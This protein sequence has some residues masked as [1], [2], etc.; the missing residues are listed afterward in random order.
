MSDYRPLQGDLAVQRLPETARLCWGKMEIKILSLFGW[1]G[2]IL[3]FGAG[4]SAPGPAGGRGG[5][6]FEIPAPVGPLP[7][8]RFLCGWGG[9]LCVHCFLQAEAQVK[10]SQRHAVPP[11]GDHFQAGLL[12]FCALT[13]KPPSVRG[14]PVAQC[15]LT[16]PRRGVSRLGFPGQVRRRYNM[17]THSCI[18]LGR[19]PETKFSLMFIILRERE[20][21]RERERD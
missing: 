2:L 11:V 19:A 13:H 5:F 21:E 15:D 1:R 12:G 9:G 8:P 10:T 14:S 6:L 18:L 20:R 16:F 17:H 7:G 3:A 4:H